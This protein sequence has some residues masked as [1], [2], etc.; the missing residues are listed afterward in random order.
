MTFTSTISLL[1]LHF[2]AAD[3][4]FFA[5]KNLYN[6]TY[7][8]DAH[9]ENC[10]MYQ[11]IK[12]PTYTFTKRRKICLWLIIQVPAAFA[13]ASFQANTVSTRQNTS[14]MEKNFVWN[15]EGYPSF[16]W[17]LKATLRKCRGTGKRGHVG[18][19]PVPKPTLKLRQ[20]AMSVCHHRAMI[21]SN[22]EY[23]EQLSFTDFLELPVCSL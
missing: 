4:L 8:R 15:L 3:I 5:S 20:F 14:V 13:T 2:L 22:T 11:N 16:L 17:I 10:H 7:K 23:I 21:N 18:A 12:Q 6:L 1:L 19:Y 9:W